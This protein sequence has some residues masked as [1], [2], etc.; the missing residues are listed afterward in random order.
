[1]DNIR[2]LPRTAYVDLIAKT[3]LKKNFI[4]KKIGLAPNTLYL[5]LAGKRNLALNKEEKLKQLLDKSL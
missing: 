3:G 4:A 1:M 5:F 2:A